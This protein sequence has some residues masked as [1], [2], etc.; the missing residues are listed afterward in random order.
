MTNPTTGARAR[1]IASRLA[2]RARTFELPRWASVGFSLAKGLSES[3][4]DRNASAAQTVL[5]TV[6]SVDVVRNILWPAR[7]NPIAIYAERHG[8]EARTSEQFVRLF[9]AT[10]LHKKFAIG[11]IRITEYQT[12]VE[13]RDAKLGHFAFVQ[14]DYGED[15][16][17]SFYVARGVDMANVL[18]DL[19]AAYDGRIHVN[20]VAGPYGSGTRSEFATFA[21]P[22]DALYGEASG[23]LAAAVAHHRRCAAAGVPRSYMLYGPPGTGKSC[24]AAALADRLGDSILKLDA[25]SLAHAT[26]RDMAFLLDNL[27]PDFVIVD[28]VDKADVARAIPT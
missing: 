20:V 5:R 15:P 6:A 28:D 16:D 12:I 17:A 13:A 8:L 3:L 11:R 7:G 18:A 1:T 4:P 25:S 26:V 24:F 27:R 21:L 2:E 19:W 14:S 22:S 23:R 10:D 9:F